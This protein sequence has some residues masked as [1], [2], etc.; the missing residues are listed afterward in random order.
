MTK[1]SLIQFITSAFDP[2]G[3]PNPFIATLKILFQDVCCKKFALDNILSESYLLV[4]YVVNGLREV[5]KVLFEILY[6]IQTSKDPIA[7][8]QVHGFC[9]ASERGFGYCVY[10]W[11]LLKSNF[12]KVVSVSAKSRVG[13]LREIV[14]P[15]LELLGNVFLTRLISSVINN[16]TRAYSTGKTGRIPVLLMH[17]YRILTKFTSHLYKRK[18][19]EFESFYLLVVGVN[20]TDVVSRGFLLTDLVKN[21][22]WFKGQNFLTSTESVGHTLQLVI[23]LILI[24]VKKKKNVRCNLVYNK[25]S[26][27]CV[28]SIDVLPILN[29]RSSHQR[30]SM[31]K[32]ALRNFAKSQEKA[33]ARASFL[34]KLQASGL[35]SEAS[36]VIQ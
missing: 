8:A 30:C 18:C 14:I 15:R 13:L 10:L 9:A 27:A 3:I 28:Q 35:A 23:N 16:L 25:D 32:G 33:C 17:G 21:E 36:C 12:V 29:N 22:V 1:K 19:N 11:F 2:L 24:L 6:C 31:K 34:I 4:F 26:K 7:F 5:Q 20:P